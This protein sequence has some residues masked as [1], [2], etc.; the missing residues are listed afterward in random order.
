MR[1][2]Y[3]IAILCIALLAG[4]KKENDANCNLNSEPDLSVAD[5]QV[6]VSVQGVTDGGFDIEYGLNGFTQGTG[7]IVSFNGSSTSFNVTD[8]GTYQ[9]YLRNKCSNGGT[10][11]WSAPQSIVV[12]GGYTSCQQPG[13]L[14]FSTNSSPYRFNWYQSFANFFDV[15]YGP[16]G[17]TIGNGT[18]IRTNNNSTNEAIMH[19]G[20]TYDFYVRAN[21]GG[22]EFSSWA[23]P[24][25]VYAAADQNINVPCTQPTNLYAY[26]INSQEITYTSDGHGSISYE[27]SFSQSN[28]SI[29]GNILTTSSPNGTV[30]NPGGFSGTYYFWIRGKCV[31]NSFTNWAVSQVQ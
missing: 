13:S 1:N 15:E 18:R 6:S 9:V 11:A 17:F 3:Y 14:N 20:I 12:D 22:N 8:Y 2:T 4:C 10:S 21:C 31:N 28:N 16:T 5:K 30:G 25:S 24:Q 19:Q 7:T 27:I 29:T 26:K 23:G